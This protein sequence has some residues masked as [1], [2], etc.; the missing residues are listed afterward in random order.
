MVYLLAQ[1][2]RLGGWVRNADPGL[3]IE[4]EGRPEQIDRFLSEFIAQRP[5]A[6][7]VTQKDVAQVPCLGS[8]WFE[9]LPDIKTSFMAETETAMD[10]VDPRRSNQG[11]HTSAPGQSNLREGRRTACD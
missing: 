6:A 9:I 10:K 2:L 4:I 1:G 7:V 8:P 11:Q 5:A 3:E